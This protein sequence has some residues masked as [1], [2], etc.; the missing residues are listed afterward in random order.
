MAGHWQLGTGLVKYVFFFQI[1]K[2]AKS[3]QKTDVRFCSNKTAK[4]HF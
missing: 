4:R 3:F 1:I 2:L